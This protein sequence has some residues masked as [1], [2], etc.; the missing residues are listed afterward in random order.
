MIARFGGDEFVIILEDMK[1]VREVKTI[2]ARIVE[3]VN[4]HV[5][6]NQDLHKVTAS[7]GAAIYPI[8]FVEPEGLLRLADEAMYRS[9]R[10]GGKQFCIALHEVSN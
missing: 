10:N 5:N 7:V 2:L 4:C 8:S 3:A 6:Q 1:S 9:K